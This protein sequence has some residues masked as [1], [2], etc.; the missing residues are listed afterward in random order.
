MEGEI[1]V[2]LLAGGQSRRMGRDKALLPWGDG[3]II[4]RMIA[5]A[6]QVPGAT[7]A[8][9]VGD[10]PAYHGRGARVVADEYPGAGPLGGIATALAATAAPRVL[11]LAIDMPLA[12]PDLL[13]A[14]VRYETDAAILVPEVTDRETGRLRLQVL[15]AIYGQE[16]LE[17]ARRRICQNER[18]VTSI[19]QDVSVERLDEA[20]VRAYDPELRSFENVNDPE[21]YARVSARNH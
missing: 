7:E 2:A 5:I 11:V 3:L 6:S 18:R 1:C 4:D 15:H 17:P 20:W 9:I 14:M 10:R 21:E 16:C 19:Y 12:S 8:M 13:A